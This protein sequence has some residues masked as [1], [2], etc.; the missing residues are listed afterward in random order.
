MDLDLH[1]KRALITGGSQGIGLA[2]AETLAEEGCH[3]NL[4]ARSHKDLEAVQQRLCSRFDVSVTI[5]AT[6]L[7]KGDNIRALAEKVADVDILIN[8]AGAIPRGNLLQ[9]DESTWRNAWDLKV[10]GYINLCRAVYPAMQSRGG[11]VIINIIGAAGERPNMD[12]IA[13]STGNAALMA[14]TRGLGAHSLREG[15]RVV[16]VNPG[17]IKTKRLESL[18]RPIAQKRFNDAEL[19]EKLIPKEAAPGDPRDVADMVAF[20]ASRRAK[21]ISGTVITIDGGYAAT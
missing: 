17:L 13:G 8:N 3:L 21:H 4:V 1:G 6:D 11:G 5:H 12:Y 18:L 16:A 19:W 15:I 2:C 14:L 7:S 9:V 10:F 20:L